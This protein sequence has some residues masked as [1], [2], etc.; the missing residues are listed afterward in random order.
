MT[1][2]ITHP[3]GANAIT[4]AE[5]KG[6]Y[7]GQPDTNPFTDARREKLAGIGEVLDST[8][9]LIVDTTLTY[10]AGQPRTVTAGDIVNTRD[11]FAYQ[12]LL[13]GATEDIQNANS[14]KLSVVA[15]NGVH[16][17]LAYGPNADGATD[18]A[19]LI[20]KANLSGRTVDLGGKDYEYSGSFLP[21]ARFINGRIYDDNRTWSFY[22]NVNRLSA[23]I[24]THTFGQGGNQ[25]PGEVIVDF[26]SPIADGSSNPKSVALNGVS[27]ATRLFVQ[28]RS[29]TWVGGVVF[30][31]SDPVA[32]NTLQVRAGNFSG[33]GETPGNRTVFV[34]EGENQSLRQVFAI[35]ASIDDGDTFVV[36]VDSETNDAILY[37]T[38]NGGT[39]WRPVYCWENAKAVRQFLRT[40]SANGLSH[41]MCG[42]DTGRIATTTDGFDTV[43]DRGQLGSEDVLFCLEQ[44][45]GE[46]SGNANILAG[47]GSGHVWLSDDAGVNWIDLGQV[48]ASYD[49]CWGLIYLSGSGSSAEYLALVHDNSEVLAPAI[50]LITNLTTGPTM[51]ATLKATL[52][53]ADKA[54]QGF[55]LTNDGTLLIGTENGKIYRSV[56]PYTT[57]TQVFDTKT[58]DATETKARAFA[59]W[60]SGEI[61]MVGQDDGYVWRSDNDGQTWVREHRC[62]LLDSPICVRNYADNGLLIGCG[63][64]L[65]TGKPFKA[66][67]YRAMKAFRDD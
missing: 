40:S 55:L 51:T 32:A 4:G 23:P 67:F 57:F 37:K 27:T 34:W 39:S 31:G 54:H 41:I 47:S 52:A 44:E 49:E 56:A 35:S 43:T 46:A 2:L 66:T 60:F 7:E 45:G 42:G 19:T 26:N 22:P 11:G 1:Q 25:F 64:G 17:M 15:Q 63:Q 65:V 53:V 21:T 16:P 30:M 3:I 36:G 10:T 29:S 20:D 59:Q 9:A 18:D 14:V 62:G 58:L 24:P 13:S 61:F 28:P 5:I 12:V 6:I 48:N 38:R 8:A 33:A 50:Y